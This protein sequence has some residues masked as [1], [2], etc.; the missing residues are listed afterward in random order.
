[1]YRT[2]TKTPELL[3]VTAE[4]SDRSTKTQRPTPL[5]VANS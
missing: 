5:W 1:M 4:H 3:A 2:D